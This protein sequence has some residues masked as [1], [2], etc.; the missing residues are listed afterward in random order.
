VG[1]KQRRSRCNPCPLVVQPLLESDISMGRIQ[2]PDM[3][4]LKHH[5]RRHPPGTLSTY[6]KSQRVNGIYNLPLYHMKFIVYLIVNR[7]SYLHQHAAKVMQLDIKPEN[8]R[9]LQVVIA[10][11]GSGLLNVSEGNCLQVNLLFP[12][13]RRVWSNGRSFDQKMHK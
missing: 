13:K 1:S 4:A 2:S 9:T 8:S 6:S 5:Q 3:V 11:F 10:V 7:V 12:A